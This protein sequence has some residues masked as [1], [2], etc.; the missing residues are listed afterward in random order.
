M[1]KFFTIEKLVGVTENQKVSPE[2]GDEIDFASK[3]M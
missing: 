1:R 2:I 3:I